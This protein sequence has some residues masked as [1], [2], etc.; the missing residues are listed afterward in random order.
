M[1]NLLLLASLAS[2]ILMNCLSMPA[3]PRL[4]LTALK[5]L[6]INAG[7]ILGCRNLPILAVFHVPGLWL[8]ND[9]KKTLELIVRV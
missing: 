6:S 3:T 8:L 7:V 4:R 2:N 1:F 9:M 5:P